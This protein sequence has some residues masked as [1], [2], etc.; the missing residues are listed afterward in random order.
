MDLVHGM[1]WYFFNMIKTTV[2][3]GIGGVTLPETNVFA[4][5]N[6]CLEDVPF[7]DGLHPQS[8]TA[9]P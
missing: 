4:R 1:I 5:E 9:R 7:S 2:T 8:L 6:Q 3:S